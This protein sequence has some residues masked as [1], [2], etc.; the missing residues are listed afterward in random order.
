MLDA[1]SLQSIKEKAHSDLPRKITII[2]REPVTT[3]AY[4]MVAGKTHPH[5][6]KVFAS[7]KHE[8]QN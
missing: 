6:T 1:N 4:M 3:M 5:A 7:K 2:K 8:I